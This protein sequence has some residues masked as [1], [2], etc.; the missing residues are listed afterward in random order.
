MCELGRYSHGINQRSGDGDPHTFEIVENGRLAVE[1][2]EELSPQVILMDVSMPEMNGLE[3]TT[4][5]R[6]QEDGTDKHTP[7][8]GLTSHALKGDREMCL[9]AGM[10][11]YMPKPISPYRLTDLIRKYLAQDGALH[12]ESA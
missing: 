11:D 12:S 10:D 3:A 9:D 6:K 4:Q 7:I 1:K 2:A 5:I 8:I